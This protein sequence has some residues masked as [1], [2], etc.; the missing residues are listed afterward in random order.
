MKFATIII[1]HWISPRWLQIC[2]TSLKSTINELEYDVWVFDNSPGHKSI[3]AIDNR[4]GEGVRILTVPDEA[5]ILRSPAGVLDWSIDHIKTPWMFSAETDI[6]FMRDGWLD[7]YKSQMPDEHIAM[8]GWY[9]Q[10]DPDLDDTRHYISPSATLYNM[11]VLRIL[12]AGVLANKQLVQSFGRKFRKRCSIERTGTG[13]SKA[14]LEGNWGPFCERRGFW[15]MYPFPRR[16]D[17]IFWHDTGSWLYYRAQ[18]Q[19][20]CVKIPGLWVKQQ[21]NKCPEVKYTYIGESEENAYI[22]HYW[23]G[24]VSHS[25]EVDD[26]V[27]GWAVDCL[28]WWL[29]REHRLWNEIVPEDI[30]AESIERGLIPDP[31][32]E[33]TFALS[34]IK[35]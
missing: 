21:P 16:V 4:L 22:L 32:E 9:W 7:W 28:E 25:F 26:V 3:Q 2:L 12:K 18:C 11:E 10:V 6:R 23:A 27:G 13:I 17:E 8:I 1:P 5:A 30:R 35:Q 34:K 33:I 29:R 31:E 14:I 24:G 20:E 19:W 15:N